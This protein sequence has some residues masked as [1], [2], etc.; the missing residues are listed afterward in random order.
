MSKIKVLCAFGVPDDMARRLKEEIGPVTIL[1]SHEEDEIVEAIKDQH[2]FVVRSKP[3]V[4]PRIIE[5]APVLRVVARPG[6]G[7]DNIDKEVCARRGV[8]VVNTPESSITS[9]SELTV[10]LA[11]S[12]MR[13]VYT[14]CALLKEGQWAKGKYTGKTVEGKTWGV[15]GFGGIGRRVSEIARVLRAEVIGFDPYVPEEEFS[16]RGVK[17]ALRLEDLLE[18]SDIV[19][20]HVVLNEQTRG[21]MS[22][23]AI[24]KMKQGAYI[25]NTSRGQVIDQDALRKALEEGH[26]GGAALDVFD[27]EPPDD[28]EMIC[29]ENLITTPHIGGSTEEA[30]QQATE[31]MVRKLKDLLQPDLTGP[32]GD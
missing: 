23:E 15:I 5:N 25:I 6:V 21:L 29:Q 18:K 16:S 17:R 24:A 19:S 9:V 4:T 13:H 26:L 28:R 8:E 11:V 27:I 14:T 30:F 22:A 1:N 12:L 3:K 20:L 2:V 32:I 31:I 7:T 10:G